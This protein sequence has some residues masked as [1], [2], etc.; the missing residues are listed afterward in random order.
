MSVIRT[1][2][3]SEIV[4]PS[5]KLKTVSVHKLFDTTCDRYYFWRWIMNL[6]PNKFH[7]AFWFGSVVHAGIEQ[8]GAGKSLK[9]ARKCMDREDRNTCKKNPPGVDLRQEVDAQRGIARLMIEAYQD[10][11][12]D[13]MKGL[14]FGGAEQHFEMPLKQSP[15]LFEGTVDAWYKDK[16]KVVLFEGKTAKRPDNDYFRKL[17]FDKQVNGYAIGLHH[18]IGKYPRECYYTVFR[19][20]QIRQRKTETPEDFFDRLEQDLIDR[21]DWYFIFYKHLFGKGAVKAVLND[22]EWMTFD[23]AAK[24]D[25]LTEDQLLDPANW[26]RND[27][28]CFDYGTCPY[29][30]LCQRT[31]SY[32]LYY[33]FF[34]MR[35]IRY[36]TEKEEL[37]EKRAYSVKTTSRM[38]RG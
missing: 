30:T 17:K 6:V 38:K 22:I 14:K 32:P 15:V 16:K 2:S 36:D 26:P 35:D 31:K 9:K 1:K 4:I 19:K 24:Y 11:V 33:R 37:N 13:K 5:T 18:L 27:R 8:I 23:L 29:F 12:K 3:R 34:T 21:K 10:I 25:Y 7:L 20:P 28:Q